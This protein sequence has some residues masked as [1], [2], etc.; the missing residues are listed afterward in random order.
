[1]GYNSMQPFE[2]QPT[3][4]KN[5]LCTSSWLKSKPSKK[6]PWSRQPVELCL[7]HSYTPKMYVYSYSECAHM[8]WTRKWKRA[9][10][11][12]LTF[13]Q[14]V[15]RRANRLLSFIRHGLHRRR[16]V[17]QFYLCVCIRWCGNVF[18]YR[19]LATIGETHTDTQTD[20][21]VYEISSWDGLRCHNIQTKF[22]EDWFRHSEINGGIHRHTAC[23]S[24]EYAFIF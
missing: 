22:H 2:C 12:H 16:R 6:L 13:R 15:L 10:L 19:C 4:R 11:W 21:E 20:R 7:D 17:K 24:Y 9:Q 23:K 3:F 5:I 8:H 18:T 1:V 14:E